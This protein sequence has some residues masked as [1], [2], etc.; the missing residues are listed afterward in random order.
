MGSYRSMLPR[1]SWCETRS[2][3]SGDLGSI[4]KASTILLRSFI[5]SSVFRTAK[6]DTN[7][8]GRIEATGLGDGKRSDDR[9]EKNECKNAEPDN[10]CIEQC[11][12]KK[13][14]EKRPKYG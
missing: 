10:Q 7:A 6:V 13:F 1:V 2:E 4:R 9:Y 11:L 8:E 3:T 14:G 5:S 12:A